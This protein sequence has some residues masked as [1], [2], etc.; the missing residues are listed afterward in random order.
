MPWQALLESPYKGPPRLI[1]FAARLDP[2]NE[3]SAC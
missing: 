1:S 2:L 3:R